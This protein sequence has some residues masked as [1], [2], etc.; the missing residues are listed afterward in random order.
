[1][2]EK[3]IVSTQNPSAL[4]PIDELVRL[5]QSLAV[6]DAALMP[7]WEDRYYSFNARWKEAE[8][9][10]SMRD[11]SGDGYFIWFSQAGAV[12]KGFAHESTVWKRL[13]G[14]SELA[15]ASLAEQLPPELEPF[16]H[17]PAFALD[18]MTFCFWRRPLDA[19]WFTWQPPVP[20]DVRFLDGSTDLLMHLDGNPVTYLDLADDSYGIRPELAAVQAVYAHQPLTEDLL[21]R[22]GSSRE[23]DEVAVELD[24]IGY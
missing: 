19:T 11:G 17:E 15:L 20:K 3:P 10:A 22:L 24:E 4:L 14:K 1:M 18:E 13:N 12:L 8:M 6:L 9:M 21:E 2:Q 5:S 16:L 7:E 23:P